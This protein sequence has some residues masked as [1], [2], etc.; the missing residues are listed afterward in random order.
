VATGKQIH[1]FKLERRDHS[2]TYSQASSVAA[3]HRHGDVTLI[4]TSTGRVVDASEATFAQKYASASSAISKDGKLWAYSVDNKIMVR[5]VQSNKLLSPLDDQSVPARAVAFSQDSSMLVTEEP[6][7][8]RLWSVVEG[9]VLQTI[10]GREFGNGWAHSHTVAF[11]SDKQSLLALAPPYTLHYYDLRSGK[12]TTTQDLPLNS[13]SPYSVKLSPD[14]T[15]LVSCYDNYGSLKEIKLYE[16]AQGKVTREWKDIGGARVLAISPDGKVLGEAHRGPEQHQKWLVLRSL[17]TGEEIKNHKLDKK[18]AGF[19]EFSSLA[20]AHDQKMLAAGSASGLIHF[21][22]ADTGKETGKLR[23]HR[24]KVL[25]VAF[26]PN[27]RYLASSAEDTTVLI[28][29]VAARV[30]S[31][32]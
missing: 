14:G 6:K 10:K 4:D 3:R 25:S 17:Q 7:Q 18:V 19:I 28:W 30:G 26:S 20:F 21:F 11:S 8:L 12:L 1:K 2:L 22:D 32:K 27:G 9:S 31:K 24:G 16:P 13:N 23:G 5:D 29:D 15:K